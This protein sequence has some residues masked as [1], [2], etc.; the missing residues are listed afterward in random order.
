[1]N[2]AEFP[3]SYAARPT[4]DHWYPAWES[5]GVFQ[6]EAR[7]DGEPYCIVIPPPNVTGSLHMGHAF[8]H[9]L[10]DATVRRK[11]M[12]GYAVLW[13]PG[14]DHAGIATQN[15]VERE[16]TKVG[17][18]RH[19]LGREAFV[20]KV[21]E[22][23]ESSGG[24]IT[25]QM[26]R[27]GVSCDWT[28]ERF[29]MDEGLSRSVRVVFVRLYEEGL[30]YRANRIINWCPR[31]HTAL[32]DIEVEHEEINGEL[33]HIRYPFE[34]GSGSITVATTRAETM[35]GD[36]AV[37]VHPDDERYQD[38]IGKMLTLPLMDRAI[39]VV[40]DEAVDPSFGTGAVKVTPAHDPNDFEIGQRH[41]LASIDI[42]T[43]D[44]V[45]NSDGGRFEGLGRFAA[46]E[47]V[48]EAL[49]TDGFLS[50]VEEHRHS[51]GHCYRCHTIVEPRL[52]LQW[53]VK[54]GPLAQPAMEAVSDDRTQF[55]PQRWEKLYF[56]WME[57]LR[58]WCISRQ[59]WWGHRI[60]AWY[61]NDCGSTIV[62]TQDQTSCSSCMSRDL[63]QDE[64]V[65]D[66][67][68]S[69]ALWPF[70]TLG[71]PDETEDLARFYPN[72]VLH[73][74]FDII[75]F[76]VARM[77]QMGLH[78]AGD[79]PF[80]EVTI[81][82][83]VRDAEGRKMSKSAG[84]VVDPLELA[85]LHGADALRFALIRAGS[86][87]QDVPLAKEWVEGAGHFVNKLWNA[88]RF[89]SM[90][91]DDR[92]IAELEGRLPASSELKLADRWILSRLAQV[93]QKVDAAFER[94]DFAE[95]VREL[96]S[97]TWGEFCDWYIELAKLPLASGGADRERAQGV[98]ATV[99]GAILRLLHPV[100]PFV[101]EELWH[102]LRGDGLMALQNWPEVGGAIGD[103][104]T[105][106]VRVDPE[107]DAAMHAVIEVVSGIRRFRSEHR[108]APSRKFDVF[109]VP[110][111]GKQA[112]VFRS[113]EAEIL[114]LGGLTQ[115]ELVDDRSSREGEQLLVAA[116]AEVVIPID[117]LVDVA[118]AREQL[119]RQLVKLEAELAKVSR[120]LGDRTFL[121]KAPADVVEGMQRRDRE[122]REAIEALVAQRA[123]LG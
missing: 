35:L 91:F 14:M 68:F 76:W 78:F 105:S 99:L 33:V 77:M 122:A 66:T 57:N 95:G 60:P 97:F 63:R 15:V 5:A 84:N 73:T 87:G 59:I 18:D 117:G 116:G 79:V 113:M 88:S 50:D 90:G 30:I 40:A 96:Q 39:P 109:V 43:I 121:S 2:D 100:V 93:V 94:Y 72:A 85:D 37:A 32:S 112:E 27:M 107:A 62:S 65:L 22:W 48:K 6:P 118:A 123:Q 47:S 110:K 38:A 8:E 55:I 102:R 3:K 80:R 46:R 25:Q 41:G 23:K 10:I 1:M 31:C 24:T 52:S 82:G 29:T 120:K 7:P 16:L 45:I 56:D 98:L 36:T 119:D 4:E 83:L 26:R 114:M 13:V 53:F 49:R 42:F 64:D 67:W 9:S 75:Y 12:Q 106:G 108:I 74:G 54:V 28:R 11:R 17:L 20:E 70:S 61:C 115:M 103:E 44:A 89:V 71:W 101:T 69:S 51:V 86:P 92:P 111:D 58:D 34:D 21:W 81:H 104:A 19:E